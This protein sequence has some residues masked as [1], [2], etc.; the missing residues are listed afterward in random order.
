[1][2]G[3]MG[4]CNKEDVLYKGNTYL[5]KGEEREGKLVDRKPGRGIKFEMKV[6]KYI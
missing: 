3:N 5:R 6:K 2:Q 4:G 1:M